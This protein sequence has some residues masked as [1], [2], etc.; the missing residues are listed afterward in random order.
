VLRASQV[1]RPA[2]QRQRPIRHEPTMSFKLSM[3]RKLAGLAG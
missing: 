1:K 2:A 3:R